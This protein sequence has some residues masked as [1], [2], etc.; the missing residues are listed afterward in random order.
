MWTGSFSAVY[1]AWNSIN[2]NIISAVGQVIHEYA[3]ADATHDDED[4]GKMGTPSPATTPVPAPKP[5]AT[6]VTSQPAPLASP[7]PPIKQVPIPA[8]VQSTLAASSSLDQQT[9]PPAI[10]AQ[11]VDSTGTQPGRQTAMRDRSRSP[12]QSEQRGRDLHRYADCLERE[13]MW[14]CK[15]HYHS[16]SRS[17]GPSEKSS[18]D[19]FDRS[20]CAS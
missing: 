16:L 7:F 2:F 9:V 6:V 17:P 10:P 12:L 4:V 20:S 11:D 14:Y 1:D 5:V 13:Y 3:D 8:S 19:R 15:A 18:P